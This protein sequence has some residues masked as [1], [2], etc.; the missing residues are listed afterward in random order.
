MHPFR[1]AILTLLCFAGCTRG[2]AT[3]VPAS[4]DDQ[5]NGQW[6]LELRNNTSETFDVS[7]VWPENPGSKTPL[8]RAWT[9]LNRF[10]VPGPGSPYYSIPM[11]AIDAVR[12]RILCRIAR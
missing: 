5:C 6:V 12:Y 2:P 7:W 9:G 10:T 11:S 4:F 1:T 3:L 8:G